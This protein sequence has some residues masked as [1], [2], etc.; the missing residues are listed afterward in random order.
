MTIKT[1]ILAGVCATLAAGTATAETLRLSHQWSTQD[2]RHKVAQIIADEVAAANVYLE[3]RIFPSESL[4]K[5]REQCTLLTGGQLDMTVLPLSYAGGQRPTFNLTLMPSLVKNHDQAARL[6]DSTLME[7]IKATAAED[8]V[9]VLVDGYLAGGFVG[10]DKCMT[11]P[12]VLEG[13]QTRAAGKRSSRC[14][15]GQV[16]QY[17]RR[18]STM[19]CIPA[20][21]TLRTP[22]PRHL[23]AS[24]SMSKWPVIH[25]PAIMHCGSCTSR[26]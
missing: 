15:R 16:P 2:V 25:S 5:V 13:M 19:P 23:S 14:W 11:S 20:F 4:F 6:N 8:D 9:M 12:A 1:A 17:P 21:W 18:R 3:I 7:E 10:K 22:H 24:A 26:C